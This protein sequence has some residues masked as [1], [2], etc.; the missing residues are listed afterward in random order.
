[1]LEAEVFRVT[2]GEGDQ[3]GFQRRNPYVIGL[4]R[5]GTA[6]IS[7]RPEPLGIVGCRRARFVSTVLSPAIRKHRLDDS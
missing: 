2:E 6:N 7:R 3:K 1:M 5:S 4:R